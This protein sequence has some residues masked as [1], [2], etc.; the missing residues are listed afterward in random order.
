MTHKYACDVRV[1]RLLRQ[2]GLGNSSTQLFCKL[3]EQ[4]EEAW[5]IKCAQYLSDCQHFTKACARGIITLSNPK[6]PPQRTPVP[7]P[8]WLLTSYCQDVLSR[9]EEVKAQ[10]TS[11]FGR[12][13]KIDSTKKVSFFSE[14]DEA[15]PRGTDDDLPEEIPLLSE[16]EV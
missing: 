11:I 8:N 12:V 10:I 14:D 9:V 16:E 2:R 13:L 15:I 1:V 7:K 3:E 5:L 4:H 6:N